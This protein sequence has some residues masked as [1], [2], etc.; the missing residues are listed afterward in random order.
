[1]AISFSALCC[2]QKKQWPLFGRPGRSKIC[3]SG[4]EADKKS[5]LLSNLSID[6][7]AFQKGERQIASLWPAK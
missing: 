5:A 3:F 2:E 1:V 4:V 6:F 7:S